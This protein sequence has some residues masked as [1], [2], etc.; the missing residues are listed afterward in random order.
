M[1]NDPDGRFIDQKVDGDL[2]GTI[3][4]L[5][6]YASQSEILKAAEENIKRK[7]KL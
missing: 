4:Q 6:L 5:F 3:N 1:K 2:G 7:Y